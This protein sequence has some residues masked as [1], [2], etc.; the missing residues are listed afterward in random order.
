MLCI[1]CCA[2]HHIGATC[3][4]L[5]VASVVCVDI[6]QQGHLIPSASC[7]HSY[8]I[9]VEKNTCSKDQI[10]TKFTFDFIYA[11]P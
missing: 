1:V 7:K 4:V 3:A 10:F 5:L 11:S 6:M 8:M 2:I 9:I